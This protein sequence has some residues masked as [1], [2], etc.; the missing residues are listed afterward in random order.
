MSIQNSRKFPEIRGTSHYPEAQSE[1]G[2][3]IQLSPTPESTIETLRS[4]NESLSQH[5]SQALARI[6]NLTEQLEEREAAYPSEAAGLRRPAITMRE[7]G[8]DMKAIDD[9]PEWDWATVDDEARRRET[10]MEE[11]IDRG[12]KRANDAER[13]VQ[14]LERIPRRPDTGNLPTP[15]S[16]LT[17]SILRTP[18]SV[19]PMSARRSVSAPSGSLGTI[20][21]EVSFPISWRNLAQCNR[22]VT[23]GSSEPIHTYGYPIS[24][25]AR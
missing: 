13:R 22:T 6:R 15:P 23:R 7:K 11:A 25:E 16:I 24:P 20:S 18:G 10:E 3:L 4:A 21:D 1:H 17:K 5:L 14:T 19:P 9:G 2:S 12:V 8:Q